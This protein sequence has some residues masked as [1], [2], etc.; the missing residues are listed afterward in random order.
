MKLTFFLVGAVPGIA[1]IC[2]WITLEILRLSARRAIPKNLAFLC[3]SIPFESD[4]AIAEKLLM[5]LKN[6][7]EKSMKEFGQSSEA[8]LYLDTINKVFL[9]RSRES[10]LELR[11]INF[12]LRRQV[13]RKRN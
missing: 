6:E 12:R 8:S 1:C 13:G 5:R 11:S 3:I 7:T 9:E 10:L 4:G 2:G